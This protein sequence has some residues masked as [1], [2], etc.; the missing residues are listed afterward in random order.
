MGTDKKIISVISKLN[1]LTQE[2]KI[3]WKRI[4][5][6]ENLT[7]GTD[8][9]IVDFF[10]TSYNLPLILSASSSKFLSIFE[11]NLYNDNPDMVSVYFPM[12]EK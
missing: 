11:I 6:P 1:R 9:K 3:E 5:P 4:H 10:A 7:L 8:E 12:G 2:G